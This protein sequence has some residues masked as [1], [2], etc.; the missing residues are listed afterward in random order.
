MLIE[1]VFR[2]Y[3]VQQTEEVLGWGERQFHTQTIIHVK[4]EKA[5]RPGRR[6]G[7]AVLKGDFRESSLE[8]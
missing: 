1:N 7:R 4:R 6:A 8:S 5:T 3:S 2:P